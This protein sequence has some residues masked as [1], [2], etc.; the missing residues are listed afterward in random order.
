LETAL[1]ATFAPASL[2]IA[3]ASA[4]LLSELA[5]LVIYTPLQRRGLVRAVL[6]SSIAGLLV[7]SIMFLWL[8]F[9]S[10]NFLA[11]QI[12][13]KAWMVLFAMPIVAF[14]RNRDRRAGAQASPT[15]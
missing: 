5:D 12:I 13:G 2:V 9:G 8:A 1:S 4:F 15:G 10:L 6:F 7:D 3:S 11:G 14:L